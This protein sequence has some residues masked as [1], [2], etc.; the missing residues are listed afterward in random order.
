MGPTTATNLKIFGT[1]LVTLGVYTWVASAIPQLESEV[2]EEVSFSAEVTP[3]EL[4][5]VGEDLFDGAGACTTCHGT[6]TRAPNL[7]EDHEGEGAIGARCG[8]RVDGMSCKEYLYESMVEPGAYLVEGFP[9]SMPPQDRI[10]TSNQIWALIAY[11]Q[12]IGGEV[13]VTAED[14]QS[15]VGAGDTGGDAAAASGTDGA[16]GG[17]PDPMTVMQTNACLGCHTLGD[18]GMEVGPSF[19]G[20]GSR[21]S[22]E[23]LR[24]AIVD[25][26]ADVPEGYE[27]VAGSMPPNFGEILTEAELDAL[28]DFLA[29]QQ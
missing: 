25:P 5:S 22:A 29:S 16:G 24:R 28:V 27:A 12:S 7:L 2:P 14:V 3:E 20:I 9:P 8:D 1:V 21:R 4:V 13:T 10:L 6:G 26:G 15:E 17:A 11:L 23:Y 18:Q 19:D